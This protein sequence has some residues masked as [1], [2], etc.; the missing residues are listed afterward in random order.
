M[1]HLKLWVPFDRCPRARLL[2]SANAAVTGES[3]GWALCLLS[4][5]AATKLHLKDLIPVGMDFLFF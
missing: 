3:S 5:H 4:A 1:C 2:L